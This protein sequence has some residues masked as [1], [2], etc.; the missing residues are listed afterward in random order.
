MAEQDEK[1]EQIHLQGRPASKSSLIPSR[2]RT[3]DYTADPFVSSCGPSNTSASQ[4]LEQTVPDGPVFP[5][6]SSFASPSSPSGERDSL[7]GLGSP[8]TPLGGSRLSTSAFNSPGQSFRTDDDIFVLEIGMRHLQMG[9]GGESTPRARMTFEPETAKRV[10]DWSNWIPQELME[11]KVVDETPRRKLSLEHWGR[12]HELFPLDL[13]EV[14]LRLVVDKLERAVR[15]ALVEHLLVVEDTKRRVLMLSVDPM[16]PHPLLS[17]FVQTLFNLYPIPISIQLFSNAVMCCV[18]AG[19]RAGLVVDIGWNETV[20]TAVYDLREVRSQRSTRGGKRLSWEVKAMVEAELDRRHRLRFADQESSKPEDCVTLQDAEEVMKKLCWCPSIPS[21]PPHSFSYG[22]KEIAMCLNSK[23]NHERITLPFH[24]FSDPVLA[25]FFPE[26]PSYPWETR[27]HLDDNEI[28]LPS[29]IYA[30]LLRTSIDIRAQL[31]QRIVFTGGASSIPGLRSRLVQSLSETIEKRGWDIADSYGSISDQRPV[32]TAPMKLHSTSEEADVEN[33][34]L[35][36]DIESSSQTPAHLQPPLPDPTLA[37][38]QRRSEQKSYL[39]FR[40]DNTRSA[41]TV[42]SVR[43]LGAWAGTSLMA[44]LRVKS[45]IEIERE[46]W[47][48]KR[49]SEGIYAS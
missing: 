43:T 35:N 4:K 3:Q 42:Q 10:G 1:Q 25:A 15:T 46:G 36:K 11:E 17:T 34:P 33:C 19:L 44:G 21:Q 16:L 22:S 14:D 49:A 8:R 41:L 28:C 27:L 26:S 48:G 30:T 37:R 5:R 20:V 31:V 32:N 29:L 40:G 23:P 39:G 18:A 6:L 2:S 47:L 13:R 7:Y 38:L 24:R 45:T 9:L 12:E